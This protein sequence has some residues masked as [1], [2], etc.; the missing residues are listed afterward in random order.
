[1]VARARFPRHHQST[2]I[3]ETAHRF[4]G[5]TATTARANITEPEK[6]YGLNTK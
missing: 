4:G 5:L 3:E 2:A 6:N 1:M